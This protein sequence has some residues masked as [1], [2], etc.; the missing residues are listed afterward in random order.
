[1]LCCII[2]SPYS[3]WWVSSHHFTLSPQKIW[4]PK[5]VLCL[6]LFLFPWSHNITWWERAPQELI[7]CRWNAAEI[8]F[9][10]GGFPGGSDNKRIHLP[11]QET[12]G[13]QLWSL[14]LEDPL[15]KERATPHGQRSL[16]GYGPWGCKGVGHNWVT[17]T[18]QKSCLIMDGDDF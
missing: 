9:R 8:C 13:M 17:N 4:A 15:V 12:Q 3:M 10:K 5:L 6:F 11:V 16:A 7:R 1:M 2:T 14:G 18:Y